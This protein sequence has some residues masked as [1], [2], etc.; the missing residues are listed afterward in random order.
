MDG[1]AAGFDLALYGFR[2]GRPTPSGRLQIDRALLAVPLLGVVL[3]NLQFAMYF[4]TFG[5]LCNGAFPMVDA[6][7]IAIDAL[8][9][10]VLR[11]D[12]E[13]LVD[14]VRPANGFRAVSDCAISTKPAPQL[15]RVAEETRPARRDTARA[16]RPLRGRGGRRTMGRVL[17]AL[18]PLIIIILGM[19]VAFIIISIL[20]GVL[21]IN[22]TI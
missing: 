14:T 3:R 7:K 15:I 17:A 18:E 8:T 6:L 10:T 9:N 4:R 2:A 20:G 22:D 13:P 11:T 5:I 19:V 16:G 21:S 1:T 12:L